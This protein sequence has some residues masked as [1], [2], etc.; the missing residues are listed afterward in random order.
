[1]N[2]IILIL[3]ITYF[4]DFK[5]INLNLIKNFEN[6]SLITIKN[7]IITNNQNLLNKIF[8]FPNNVISILLINYLL[9]T[10]IARVK[11]TNIFKGPLRPSYN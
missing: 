1:M 6:Y 3:I 9:L 2:L 10:L 7:F 4:L 5:S 8:N 11:I